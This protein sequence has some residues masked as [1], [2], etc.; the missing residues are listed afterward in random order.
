MNMKDFAI[1]IYNNHPEH[2]QACLTAIREQSYDRAK[3]EV[4]IGT[5]PLTGEERAQINAWMSDCV[6]K[7]YDV[8][9][10]AVFY[11]DGIAATEA[12]ICWFIDS[13]VLPQKPDT[14][15]RV[16]ENIRKTGMVACAM[17]FYD[18]GMDYPYQ[19]YKLSQ[20]V[21]AVLDVEQKPSDINLNLPSYF[22]SR[23]RLGKQVFDPAFGVDFKEK[24]LLELYGANPVYFNLG[25]VKLTS[26]APFEDNTSKCAVQYEFDWYTPALEQWLAYIKT[27][28]HVPIYVQEV[29]MY[30]IYAKYNCNTNERN[31]NVLDANEVERFLAATK[32]LLEYLDD[33]II[34]QS[35]IDSEYKHW[36]HAFKIPR[37]LKFYLYK[38]KRGDNFFT[39]VSGGRLFESH[40]RLNTPILRLYYEKVNVYAINY[41]NGKLLFDC[42]VGIQDYLAHDDIHIKMV[43][44]GKEVPIRRNH[45]YGLSRAFGKV[46]NE[47][48]TFQFE[49]DVHERFGSLR[50]YL[51]YDGIEYEMSFNFVKIQARLNNSKRAYW[52]GDGFTVQNKHNELVISRSSALKTL[53][54]EAL[55]F[56]SKIKNEE[57]KAY[58]FRE[59]WLRTLYF[60]SKPFLKKKNIWITFDKLYKAGD[61][62]EYMYQY[63]LQNGLNIYYIIKRDAPDFERLVRQNKKRV[64]VYGSTRCKLYSLH[65]KVILDTHANA[66]SYCGFDGDERRF[67]AGLFNPEIICIQHGLSMQELGQF[68]NRL[69]D[70]IRLYCCASPYEIENLSKPEYDFKPEQLLL[71]G[72]ARFD[73]LKNCDQKIILITPTWRRNVVN[74]SVAHFKKK[75]NDNFKNSTYFKIYNGLINNQKLIECAKHTGYRII[76]LLHP[77]M[78]SQME[79][80]KGDDY[81]ELLQATG[82]MNYEKILTESSLMVTDYSGVQYDFAY[83]KKALIYYHPDAL[84]PHYDTGMMDFATM[85]FGPVCKNEETLVNELCFYMQNGC[86]IK[87][88]YR[89]RDEKFFAFDDHNNCERIFRAVTRYLEKA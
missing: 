8:P 58:V 82:D 57:S 9:N 75:H 53:K 62:G 21:T 45:V 59:F 31:K 70:N 48:Y 10:A 89:E 18:D 30:M 54:L 61:N 40:D 27:F 65:A 23:K 88:E 51:I 87:P 43:Y 5:A 80:F 16:C 29:V 46:I 72:L 84:P 3:I 22:I 42:T 50:A 83:M 17:S 41:Q 15:K 11:N 76:Y 47:K 86:Q 35:Q 64:L 20:S 4:V 74:S 49:V 39:Y 24:F 19:T 38:L 26:L 14:F 13:A 2:L 6:L 63:G 56:L 85:G 1:F 77:A 81:I 69:F 68:Q 28:R 7:E 44:G 79:D 37:T 25:T 67:V 73:G 78:S 36:N 34:L 52:N 55:F 32:A 66:I 71:T 33:N 12:Q 60:L